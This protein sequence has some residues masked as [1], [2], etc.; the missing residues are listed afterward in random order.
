M[1][2]DSFEKCS[3]SIQIFK[4]RFTNP[5]RLRNEGKVIIKGTSADVVKSIG[6]IKL[7]RSGQLGSFE[8]GVGKFPS[9][10]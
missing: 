2:S 9:S 5:I 3:F 1:R 6:K 10:I 4:D 8:P 7:R